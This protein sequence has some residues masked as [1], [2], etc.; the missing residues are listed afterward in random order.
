M[1]M[2]TNWAE[3][4]DTL[5]ASQLGFRR[6]LT[7][8]GSC[9][10]LGTN[11]SDLFSFHINLRVSIVGACQ[12]PALNVKCW[13]KDLIQIYLLDKCLMASLGDI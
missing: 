1:R 6:Q 10:V 13:S 7:F 11:T 3:P 2:C 4:V 9:S 8:P 12:W 5:R